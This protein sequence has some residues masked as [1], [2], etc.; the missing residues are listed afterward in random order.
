[1]V[2]D[3]GHRI[4]GHKRRAAGGALPGRRRPGATC[5][6]R[7]FMAVPRGR[8]APPPGIAPPACRPCVLRGPAH[9]P[10]RAHPLPSA[11][12]R[13]PLP[14]GRDHM[15]AGRAGGSGLPCT[16]IPRPGG[17][18]ASHTSKGRRVKQVGEFQLG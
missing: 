7:K 18:C 2:P 9:G 10:P 16:V 1:M 11:P 12:S 15:A 3:A 6:W 17:L 8:A 14:D 5:G 4:S 13:L